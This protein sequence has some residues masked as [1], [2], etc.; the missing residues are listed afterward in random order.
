MKYPASHLTPFFPAFAVKIARK[1]NRVREKAPPHPTDT[2]IPFRMNTCKS[3]SKQRTLSP[4]RMNTCEKTGGGGPLATA[5]RE[6]RPRRS[7]TRSGQAAASTQAGK[8]EERSLCRAEDRRYVMA[9][10]SL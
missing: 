7:P 9:K 2:A 6:K 5:R 10:S 3:V 1:K 8:S 4:S